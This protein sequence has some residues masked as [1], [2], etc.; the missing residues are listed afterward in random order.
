MDEAGYDSDAAEAIQ[1]ACDAPEFQIDQVSEFAKHR[2]KILDRCTDDIHK[3]RGF[4]SSIVEPA[5][6]LKVREQSEKAI[7]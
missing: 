1:K 4:L 6:V 2:D 3:M 5:E 7:L